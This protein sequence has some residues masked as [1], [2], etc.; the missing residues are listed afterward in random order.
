M[1]GNYWTINDYCNSF[2]SWCRSVIS[3]E[4]LLG[5]FYS[6]LWV[7]VCVSGV[8]WRACINLTAIRAERTY[9]TSWTRKKKTN[10][11]KRQQEKQKYEMKWKWKMISWP[12]RNCTMC[13][14]MQGE[15]ENRRGS[16][17]EREMEC[18]RSEEVRR[19]SSNCHNLSVTCRMCVN[20]DPE[21]AQPPGHHACPFLCCCCSSSFTIPWP[22]TG[23]GTMAMLSVSCH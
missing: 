14:P 1:K 12:R 16:W 23:Q 18:C 11:E 19:H 9:V 17:E 7:C 22:P 2:Q 6:C 3:A 13:W 8:V 4:K 21:T 20:V 10:K 5:I 15:S